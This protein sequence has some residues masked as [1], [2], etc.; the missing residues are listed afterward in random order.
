M[1]PETLGHY[2]IIRLLGRGGMGEVYLAEDL[3][4]GRQVALKILPPGLA[5][6]GRERFDREARAVAALNH[7]NIVTLHSIDQSNDPPFLT[8]EFVDGKPLNE[9]IPAKGLP[10]DRLLK[11]AIPFAD[12][13]GA[14]HQRGILHRDLKPANVM[15]TADGRVKVLD[16]GLAKL[17]EDV[18]VRELLP[19]QELTGEGRIIGTVAYMSP[20]Q[21]EGQTVD[22]R[23]DV[24]SIGVVL[25]ELATGTRPFTGDTSLSILSAILKD[26]PRPVSE[27]KPELPRDFTRII[28]RALN[29][30]PE[31]RYQSA[32]DLRNDLSAVLEDLAS[33]EA[34]RPTSAA[35]MASPARRSHAMLAVT[36]AA[37]LASVGV[38]GWLVIRPS[39]VAPPTASPSDVWT[40]ARLTSNGLVQLFAAVSPDGRY[41]AYTQAGRGMLLRQV[42]TGTD[43]TV[44]PSGQESYDGIAFSR[45]SSFIY[46]SVYPAGD[47]LA[48]LYRVPVIG[49]T[50][51]K[52]LANVD[53]PVTF[54]PDGRRIAYI[55]DYPSDRRATL[56]IANADGTGRTTLAERKRPDR[57]LTQPGRLA[58]SPDGATIAAPVLDGPGYSLAL[59]DVATGASRLINDTRWPLVHAAQWLPGGRELIVVLRNSG[60]ATNQLWRID[61][62]T[63]TG[64]AITRDLFNYTD[65]TVAA[66]GNAFVATAGLSESTLWTANADRLDAITQITTSAADGEGARG[67]AWAHDGSIVYVSRA[68]GNNDLWALD[69]TTGTRRQLTSDPGDDAQPSIS[70]D[71]RSIAF[72]SNRQ[73]GNRIWI[74]HTDGTQPRPA[75]GGPA[76]TVPMWRPDS[77][78]ILFVKANDDLWQVDVGGGSE[79]SLKGLWPARSGESAKTFYPRA[80][81]RHGLVAGF[82]NLNPGRGGG[83]RLSFAPIDGSAPPKLLELT[84]T[85]VGIPIAWAPDGQAIDIVREA[86]NLW[87][88]PIDG[89]PGF[90]LTSFTGAVMTRSFAWS[91][92]GRLVLSRGE[93]KTD[94]VLFK[95]TGSH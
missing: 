65:V 79:R 4:L 59:I 87:R 48:T 54:S 27:L 10:L 72:E 28:R 47:N 2:R 89:R 23:S 86:G 73:G 16:F 82:E 85:G 15:V 46:F 38:V 6:T 91:A 9:L 31:Q 69:P 43:V 26:T 62:A 1:L 71:G 84:V 92:D 5:A 50:P 39:S 77:S 33:G 76:N 12:A 14:A 64:V 61:A 68:G 3:T 78:A 34:P 36:A 90:S 75:S 19:T 24:F 52:L 13:V 94:L 58:W 22:Q 95:K 18:E 25:Y 7:P 42:A 93:N 30:D 37:V 74:M 21:A 17:Q 51:Q 53:T 70:P 40:P 44:R 88:Y 56:E 11:I 35:A 67:V 60:S 8:M 80:M 55:V 49:G 57:F 45:D 41:V 32:K 20:E 66:D 29:K 83:V 81:S 63:G